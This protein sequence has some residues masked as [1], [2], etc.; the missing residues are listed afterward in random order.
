M[1]DKSQQTEKPTQRKLEKARKEGQFPVSKEFVGGVQFLVFILLL[2]N[3]GR[4]WLANLVSTSHIVLE[5]GFHAELTP[6]LVR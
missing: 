6:I 4:S 3:Y 5:R 2:S 1:P